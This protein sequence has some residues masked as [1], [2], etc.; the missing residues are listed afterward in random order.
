MIRS[1]PG[2]LSGRS[3]AAIAIPSQSGYRW[4]ASRWAASERAD[5][6]KLIS[7]FSAPFTRRW[8]RRRPGSLRLRRR[9][10][11]HPDF[12]RAA[13]ER[14]H[15]SL[16]NKLGSSLCGEYRPIH[17]RRGQ[18]FGAFAQGSPRRAKCRR[19]NKCGVLG[20][21]NFWVVVE[22]KPSGLPF[23]D[24]DTAKQYATELLRFLPLT[25]AVAIEV[26]GRNEPMR[27]LERDRATGAWTPASP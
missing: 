4:H 7:I 2:N 26:Y 21:A 17:G 19:W 1:R 10:L 16:A 24:V 11:G 22:G 8:R 14:R 20:V 6:S 18:A 3:R 13:R 23:E 25:A 15:F 12:R 5:G 9:V 27:K